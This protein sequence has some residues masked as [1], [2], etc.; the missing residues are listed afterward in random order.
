MESAKIRRL[1]RGEHGSLPEGV[2][3]EVYRCSVLK[4]GFVSSA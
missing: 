2:K 3:F 4:Y 1:T